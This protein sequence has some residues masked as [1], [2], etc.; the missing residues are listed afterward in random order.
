MTTDEWSAIWKN[1]W[2]SEHVDE[3]RRGIPDMEWAMQQN[4]GRPMYVMGDIVEFKAGGY[5]VIKDVSKAHDGW[6]VSY[7]TDAIE[8]V[9][10]HPKTKRAWH[11]E[12]DFERLVEISSIRRFLRKRNA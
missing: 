6:P 3:H 11:Y 8:G 4:M 9:P 7:A 10:D 1:Y 12:N 2:N 5:G